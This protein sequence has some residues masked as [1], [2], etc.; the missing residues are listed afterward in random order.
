VLDL[1]PKAWPMLADENGCL[2]EGASTSPSTIYYIEHGKTAP[3]FRAIRD[4]SAALDCDPLD[5]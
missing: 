2:A 3:S 4:I 1:D 5:I